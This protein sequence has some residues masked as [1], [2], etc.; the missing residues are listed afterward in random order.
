MKQIMSFET[1]LSSAFLN[2]NKVFPFESVIGKSTFYS[3]RAVMRELRQFIPVIKGQRLLDIGCGPMNKTGIFH[4][5]GFQC[6]AADDLSDPWH[7]TKGNIQKIKD[8]AKELGMVF[9]H[10]SNG[11][12]SIPFEKNSF[13]VVCSFAVIEHLHES[14][15]EMLNAMGVFAKV[16]GLLV[17]TMPNSVNFRKR[18]SVLL[19]RTNYP[20][21]DQVYHSSGTWRGH[22]REYTLKEVEYICRQSGFEVISTNHVEHL[23]QTKLKSPMRQIYMAIGFL[24]PTT[25]SSLL[26][27]CRKPAS[28]TPSRYDQDLFS[29]FRPK[30]LI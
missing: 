8:Y 9:H 4:E 15:R 18:L 7:K 2:V 21:V 16:G 3:V 28:W 17:I 26:V 6:Y 23:A 12:Y 11:D 1:K 24:I 20:P 10:Q 22:V 14:P 29:A 13:D 5:M 27:I 30:R 19:G 25:R